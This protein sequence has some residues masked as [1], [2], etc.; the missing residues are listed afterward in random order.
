TYDQVVYVERWGW[1]EVSGHAY[2]TDYDLKGHI[3]YSGRDLRAHRIL[4][5]PKV[6]RR[7]E[8]K[9]IIETLR[10]DFRDLMP[11]LIKTLGDLNAEVVAMELQNKGYIDVKISEGSC[12]R[13]TRRHIAVITKEEKRGVESFIPHVAEPSFGAE[14]VLY[15]ALEY[16]YSERDGRIVLKLP[17]DIAPI[18]ASV[19]PIVKKD[20]F[21]EIAL[22]IYDN[23]K[24]ASISVVY[25]DE[26]AIG[27]RYMRVDEI[28]VPFAITVDGHTLVDG[29]VTVRDRDTWQQVRVHEKDL[30]KFI[31]L[32][33]KNPK[34][35]IHEILVTISAQCS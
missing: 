6:V 15:T 31:K 12:Y 34:L 32:G 20:E 18:K 30:V 14:R 33:C 5:V 22:R 4:K 2:R 16:A 7:V 26:G 21:I 17:R 29:T 9:P 27:R 11:Q 23:L 24:S 8:V 25:D 10:E 19:F 35:S 28:G 1:I 3:K 13:L